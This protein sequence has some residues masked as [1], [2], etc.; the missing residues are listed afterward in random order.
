MQR[1]LEP[2]VMDLEAEVM[3]YAR[4]DFSDSNA[5]FVRTVLA[6]LGR[7][8]RS[9]LDIGCGPADIPILLAQACPTVDV[10][11]V[12]ASGPMLKIAREGVRRHGLEDR[13]T[14]SEQRLPGLV[15][16]R[17]DFDLIYSKDMLH[18]IPDPAAFWA[19]I[20]RLQSQCKRET[21]VFVMDLCRPE[22]KDDA[23]RIVE[24]VSAN[25]S[26]LLKKDFYNSLLAAFTPT[27]I[28]G[29]LRTAGLKLAVAPMG[30]RHFQVSGVLG[31]DGR[32]S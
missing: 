8:P 27:E 20:A 28:Q 4:A 6:S 3:A 24:S 10:V 12:D 32:D 30:P 14:L 26:A 25:E 1:V 18:H 9:A 31:A 11:A 17:Y 13:V 5:L 22:S 19:E 15:F 7:T 21:S 29:Q 16:P 23:L 2:E